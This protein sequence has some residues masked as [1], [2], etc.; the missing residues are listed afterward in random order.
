[1]NEVKVGTMVA[2]AMEVASSGRDEPVAHGQA[3]ALRGE[4]RHVRRVVALHPDE[5]RLDQEREQ[6]LEVDDGAGMR[7]R[8]HAAVLADQRDRF[9][10]RE[11]DAGDVRRRFFADERLERTVVGRD[12][13]RFV[14]R[15]SQVRPSK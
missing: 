13:S 1:M 3:Q 6:P 14:Q 5:T 2:A 10:R 12:V 7:E 8:R 9:E 15:L 11:P 4:C